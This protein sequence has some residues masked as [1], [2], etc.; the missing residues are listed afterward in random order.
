MQFCFERLGKRREKHGVIGGESTIDLYKQDG[1]PSS[2]E[3]CLCFWSS[4]AC[5][6]LLLVLGWLGLPECLTT[7]DA[8][9]LERECVETSR[10]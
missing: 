4:V 1:F 9:E 7:A 6:S 5:Q 2:R 3:R 8:A 10:P